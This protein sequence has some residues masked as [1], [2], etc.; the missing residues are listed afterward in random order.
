M[1]TDFIYLIQFWVP[2]PSC[3]NYV[4]LFTL[5]HGHT[6]ARNNLS[7]LPTSEIGGYYVS[8]KATFSRTARHAETERGE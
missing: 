2:L 4:A 6:V 5:P 7:Q 3:E 1:S 8:L